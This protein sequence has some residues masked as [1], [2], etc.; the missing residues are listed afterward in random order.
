MSLRDFGWCFIGSGSITDRVIPDILNYSNG[1]YP[2]SVY[3]KTYANARRFADK[4]GAA[5]YETVE[6]ALSDPDVRAAYIC[7]T[8][9]SHMKYAVMALNMGIPVLCEK[10]AAMNA[11]EAREMINAAKRNNT[12]FM[13]AMWTRHNPVFKEV[14]EWVKQGRIGTVRSLSASFSFS[15]PY[16]PGSRLFDIVNG[17]ALLDVG[18]YTVAFARSVF[19]DMPVSVKACADFT[20]LGANSLNAM[21]F[22][23]ANGAIARLF[24][25]TM[26]DEPNDAYISGENGHIFIPRFWAPKR[27]VLSVVNEAEL[28][29][30]GCFNGEGFQ[31][32]FDAAKDDIVEGRIQNSLVTHEFTLNV[33]ELID[34]ASRLN[35]EVRLENGQDETAMSDREVIES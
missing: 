33:M 20:P 14:I 21:I 18:I 3:S 29:F 34:K 25:G 15:Q 5:A 28:V 2:A 6:G 22:K 26:A 32:E 8:N 31:Y 1:S 30:D 7:T 12:Y 23:Y 13:E 10:P 19:P 17:G 4:Y 27:A 24:S 9:P 35:R 16:D 11:H